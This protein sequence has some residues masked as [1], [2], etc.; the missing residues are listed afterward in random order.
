MD[1]RLDDRLPILEITDNCIVSKMG[2]L[3]IGLEITKPEIFTLSSDNYEGLHQTFVKALKVLPVGSVFHMQDI[4]VKDSYQAD[5][6]RAGESFLSRASERFFNERA[7]L[8]HTSYI[9]LTKK[10]AGR[11]PAT[12]AASGLLRRNLVPQ[13]T[14]SPQVI[15]EFEDA[16]GQFARILSDSG[17]VHVRRLGTEDLVSGPK[18]AGLIE[19]YC[20]L[21]PNPTDPVI[22]DIR[23]DDPIGIG[24]QECLLFTLSDPEHLPLSGWSPDQL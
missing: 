6:E 15:R 20:Y 13:D 2:D 18:K 9:Y 21:N 19:Q 4:F 12:S 16:A 11:K 7:L 23:L 22:R 10:P 24:E 1:T 8:R 5:Y 3:T 17:L 14:L